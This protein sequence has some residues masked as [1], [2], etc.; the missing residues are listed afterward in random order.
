MIQCS[1]NKPASPIGDAGWGVLGWV[2]MGMMVAPF[3][4]VGGIG[5]WLGKRAKKS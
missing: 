3:V 2:V 5:Y 4:V 1:C